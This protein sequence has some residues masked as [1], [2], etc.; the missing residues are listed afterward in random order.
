M[1]GNE[2]ISAIPL[3]V[4]PSPVGCS[5]F[6]KTIDKIFAINMGSAKFESLK[7]ALDMV[8]CDRPTTFEFMKNILDSMH[9]E[10]VRV[11]LYNELDGIFDCRA[12]FAVGDHSGG[13]KIVEIDARPSDAIALALRFSTPIYIVASVLEKLEDMA[14]AYRKLRDEF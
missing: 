12:T 3:D 5:M 7:L 13:K 1:D 2:Y 14:A 4:L 10:F 11:D 6:F 8:D 9:C